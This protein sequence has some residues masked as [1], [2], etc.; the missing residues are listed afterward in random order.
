MR[1]NPIEAGTLKR[2][3]QPVRFAALVGF[4]LEVAPHFPS[5]GDQLQSSKTCFFLWPFMPF[6]G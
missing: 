5:K 3:L 2:E 4:N 6:S 1:L